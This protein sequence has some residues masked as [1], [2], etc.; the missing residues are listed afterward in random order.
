MYVP[1]ANC[2]SNGAHIK[3]QVSSAWTPP[4]N[5]FHLRAGGHVESLKIHLPNTIF[6]HLDIKDFFG[7]ISKTRVTRV[8]KPYFGYAQAREWANQ[9][10]VNHIEGEKKV[11]VLPFG[12]VQSPIL[13]SL[14]LSKSALG[15]TLAHV[16]SEGVTV[17]VYMDDIVLSANCLPLLTSAVDKIKNGASVSGFSF[18]AEKEE[19]PAKKISAFNIHLENGELTVKSNR[20]SE[21][22]QALVDASSEHQIKGILGYVRTVS[23]IQ[24]ASLELALESLSPQV[25]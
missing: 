12:F 9:S 5:Y 16:A 6:V 19:G 24:A 14:C 8:L 17:S 3:A 4:D 15:S 22:S 7:S 20:L 18:N 13:A 2:A 1:S 11:N 10:T 23:K 25:I 21:F